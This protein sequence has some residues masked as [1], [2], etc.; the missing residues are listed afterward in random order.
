MIRKIISYFLFILLLTGAGYVLLN[1]RSGTMKQDVS[2][3]LPAATAGI[4]RFTISQAGERISISRSGNGWTLENGHRAKPEVVS[5][6]FQTLQ[7]FEI[8]APAARSDRKELIQRLPEK[9]REVSFFAEDRLLKTFYIG[10]DSLG[11]KGTYI[12]DSHRNPYRVRVKGFNQINLE[13]FFS[14]ETENWQVKNLLGYRAEQLATVSAEYP[15]HPAQNFSLTQHAPG[16]Y[17][18]SGSQP[19]PSELTDAGK[20][21]DYMQ[22]FGEIQY[23]R[24]EMPARFLRPGPPDVRL[25][26]TLHDGGTSFDIYKFYPEKDK[27]LADKNLALVV[28]LDRADT[29]VVKYSDLDPL[30]LTV[31]DF[32]KK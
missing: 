30:L 12:M 27:E 19:I 13:G 26:I 23:T 11:V 24:V 29:V 31:S 14:L 8:V 6:F 17:T 4:D 2:D 16:V 28:F 25:Q 1:H 7:R 15:A 22:F 32:Q 20:I 3:F 18:L 10:Y 5:F 21:T 9:G